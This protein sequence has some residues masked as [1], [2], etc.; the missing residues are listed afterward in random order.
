MVSYNKLRLIGCDNLVNDLEKIDWIIDTDKININ[1]LITEEYNSLNLLS[2]I[3]NSLVDNN[4][5]DGEIIV[6][7]YIVKNLCLHRFSRVDIRG[8]MMIRSSMLND[9]Y[10]E[11]T[12]ITNDFKSVKYMCLGDLHLRRIAGVNFTEVFRWNTEKY[13]KDTGKYT[14]NTKVILKDIGVGDIKQENYAVK[15]GEYNIDTEHVEWHIVDNKLVT[16]YPID[17]EVEGIDTNLSE[18]NVDKYISCISSMNKLERGKLFGVD[19]G[20]SSIGKPNN[21][22]TVTDD[23]RIN[24][25]NKFLL[26][27]YRSDYIK[28]IMIQ[29]DIKE[30]NNLIS[31]LNK[32]LC[33][34]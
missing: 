10:H 24:E 34:K 1:K 26:L 4:C 29:R 23:D 15:L 33:S 28:Y 7:F 17:G 30:V 21:H 12:Y 27:D 20:K 32:R 8:I 25:L 9:A 11:V 13:A 14:K 19:I 22:N 5:S 2:E 3:T 16:R 18:Y 31:V 6:K